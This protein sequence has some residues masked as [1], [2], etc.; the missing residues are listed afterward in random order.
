M[1]L[2]MIR[3][4]IIVEG[5]KLDLPEEITADF[6]YSIQ[7][8]REPDKRTT[9]FSKTIE[10]PGTPLINGLFAHIWNINTENDNDPSQPNIGYNFNPNKAAKCIALVDNIEVFRGVMRM[11]AITQENKIIKYSTNVIGRL[12]D[13]L[14]ALADTKLA[15]LDFSDLNHDLTTTNITNS[16][17]GA[18][19]TGYVYPLIDY[20]YS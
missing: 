10:L 5:Y 7:D 15:N 13:I 2:Y 11:S 17:Y 12:S 18:R 9:D 19:G 3:S 14:L 8:I 16:W 6:T 20:G 1:L 4:S